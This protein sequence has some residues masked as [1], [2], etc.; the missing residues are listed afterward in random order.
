VLRSHWNYIIN[1]CGTSK[2][3]MCCDESKRAT[4]ELRF[5]QTCASCIDQLCIQLHLALSAAMDFVVMD[6]DC[7]N[8][9]ANS[10]SPTHRAYIRIDDACVDWYRSRRGK[11]VDR[12]LVLPVL[13]ALQGHLEAG[14]V[15]ESISTRSL[16]ISI[17]CTPH[18][19]AKYLLRCD[20]R[21]SFYA[22]KST[23]SLSLA[24]TLMW[25]KA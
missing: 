20:R 7:T 21:S 22:D 9:H 6:T 13:K 1:P 14:A 23:T 16:T 3:R 12:S 8:S 10:P 17:S 5:A 19:R 24:P 2:A 11:E 25:R 18:T 4:S 15:W